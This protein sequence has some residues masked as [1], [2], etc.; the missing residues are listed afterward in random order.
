MHSDYVE[1]LCAIWSLPELYL[2][3]INDQTFYVPQYE[4]A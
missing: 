3:L 1:K 2:N 4:R